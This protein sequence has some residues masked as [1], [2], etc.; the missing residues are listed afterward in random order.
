MGLLHYLKRTDKTL[1]ETK[2]MLPSK[3]NSS[4]E[5]QLQL[6]NDS[7]RKPVG[8]EATTNGIGKKWCHI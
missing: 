8:N 6:V 4:S 1:R 7:V 2:I 5:C 3:L